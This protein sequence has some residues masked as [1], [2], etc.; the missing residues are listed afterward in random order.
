MADKF[1]DEREAN[2]MTDNQ[3][4]HHLQEM[5]VLAEHS[6]NLEEFIKELKKMI[7]TYGK[8]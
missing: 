3:F 2:G 1:T 4:L 8:K 7:D 6:A 5:L